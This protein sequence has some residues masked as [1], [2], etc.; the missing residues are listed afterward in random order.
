MKVVVSSANPVKLA[1][2]RQA[3]EQTFPDTA[4]DIESCTVASGVS[5]QPMNDEET[6]RGAIN[7][8]QAARQA[9]ADADYWVGLEGGIEVIDGAL[10]AS[11][12]MAVLGT[13]DNIGLSRTMGLPLPPTIKTLVDD[14]MELGEANDRVFATLNSKQGGGAFGLLTDG[15]ITRESVY[16]DTMMIA[17]M[18]FT[19]DLYPHH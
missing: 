1:A 7:R 11:A 6:R 9:V 17:L 12:W 8:A 14:G 18:P 2:T 16:A 3:F 10:M 4:I 5:D 13:G 15:R 19:H